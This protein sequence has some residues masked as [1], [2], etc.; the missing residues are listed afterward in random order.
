MGWCSW[1]VNIYLFVKILL[2]FIWMKVYIC[3]LVSDNWDYFLIFY[4]ID[5]YCWVY[6]KL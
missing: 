1:D 2:F 4:E 5:D 3:Y 6:F